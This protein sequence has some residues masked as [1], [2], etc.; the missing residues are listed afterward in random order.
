MILECHLQRHRVRGQAAAYTNDPSS[1]SVATRRAQL[2]HGTIVAPLLCVTIVAPPPTSPR[3]LTPCPMT[4]VVVTVATVTIC[5]SHR[6]H[7]VH[8]QQR[9]TRRSRP[10]SPTAAHCRTLQHTVAGESCCC[11]HGIHP[12][13][14]GGWRLETGGRMPMQKPALARHSRPEVSDLEA[15]GRG[16][17]GHACLA[18]H[19]HSTLAWRYMRPWSSHDCCMSWLVRYHGSR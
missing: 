18:R 9:S 19:R 8:P 5:F 14:S 12:L 4:T 15:G 10:S 1:T 11:L 17:S 13:A 3:Q 7:H 16:L 2:N 6:H